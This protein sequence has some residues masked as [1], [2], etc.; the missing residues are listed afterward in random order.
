MKFT[1]NWLKKYIDFDLSNGEL[2]DRLTMAG[3]EVDSVEDLYPGLDDLR[4]GLVKGV[5]P[6]PNADRLSLCEVDDG[7]SVRRVVCG[8]PNVRTGMLTALAVPGTV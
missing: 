7:D 5:K 8:A 3:L 1:V 4:V 2:A 6:H